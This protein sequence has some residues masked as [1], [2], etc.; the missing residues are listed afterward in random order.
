MNDP[1]WFDTVAQHSLGAAGLLVAL[2]GTAYAE[3]ASTSP[4]P[5]PGAPAAAPAAPTAAPKAPAAA[6]PATPS[7]APATTPAPG[8]SGAPPNAGATTAPSAEPATP[9]ETDETSDGAS[10][11][12]AST[13][14]PLTGTATPPLAPVTLAAAPPPPASRVSAPPPPEDV[15]EVDDGQLGTHQTH[16]LLSGGFRQS[17]VTEA[18]YDAFSKDNALPQAS[19]RFGRVLAASGPLSLAVDLA[20]DFGA[21]S[22]KARGADSSLVVH[23]LTAGAEGRYHLFRRWF[24]FGRVAPGALH[25]DATV[26]DPVVDR[27]LTAHVWAFAADF[28]AGSEVEIAGDARGAST[29]PRGWLGAEGGYGWAAGSKLS[30]EPAKASSGPVRLQPLSL[31]E[32]AVRGAFVRIFGTLTF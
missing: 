23:R 28:S 2:A 25:A 17:F 13:P 18:G 15:S 12:P 32:L 27:D 29:R 14:A 26:N 5:A 9:D 24:F 1:R 30:V 19:F 10:P 7:S 6:P 4:R 22:A 21:T 8:D 11:A 20:W 16:W 3:P 31:G